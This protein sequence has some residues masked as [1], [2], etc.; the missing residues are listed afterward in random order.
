MGPNVGDHGTADQAVP[1]A[2]A[3][4]PEVPVS[5]A[6]VVEDV[7]GQIRKRI[8]PAGHQRLIPGRGIRL[9]PSGEGEAGRIQ[10]RIEGDVDRRVVERSGRARAGGRTLDPE[11]NRVAR[12]DYRRADVGHR[13]A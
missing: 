9:G 4:G 5:A 11:G 1:A 8:V 10:R 6:V 12:P 3:S 13:G 7:A 2:A